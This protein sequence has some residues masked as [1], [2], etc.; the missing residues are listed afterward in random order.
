M[1]NDSINNEKSNKIKIEMLQNGQ[2]VANKHRSLLL[3]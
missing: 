3:I 1:K 2:H